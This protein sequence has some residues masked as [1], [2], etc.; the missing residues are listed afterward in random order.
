MTLTLS[1]SSY[2]RDFVSVGPQSSRKTAAREAGEIQLN[3]EAI[4]IFTFISCDKIDFL[5]R[6]A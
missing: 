2:F 4:V 5:Y 3:E 6:T 1:A